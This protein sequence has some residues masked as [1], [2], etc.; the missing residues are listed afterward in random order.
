M[1]KR[2][3]LARQPR[4]E[5]LSPNRRHLID[6]SPLAHERTRTQL[7]ADTVANRL[8][9]AAQDR[10]V[11]AQI[12][13]RQHPPI[14]DELIARLDDD[15]ITQHHPLDPNKPLDPLTAHASM[16]R[17]QH[18]QAIEGTLRADLLRDPNPSVRNDHTQK[19]RIAPITENQRHR[20]KASENRV[21]NRQHIGADNARVRTTRNATRPGI[22][23][24][25]SRGLVLSQARLLTLRRPDVWITTGRSPDGCRRFCTSRGRKR[26]SHSGESPRRMIPPPETRIRSTCA[27]HCGIPPKHGI[28]AGSAPSVPVGAARDP[29]LLCAAAAGELRGK[30]CGA[31]LRR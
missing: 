30:I 15:E 24:A 16:W 17:H 31:W 29:A 25:P 7:I 12:A 5:T 9:L 13:G 10:L 27:P 8:G 20:T 4:R 26:W 2:S 28:A 19:Q 3:R 11:H 18:R 22:A 6:T 21:E 1:T 14:G 23:A